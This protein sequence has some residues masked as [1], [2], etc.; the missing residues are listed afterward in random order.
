MSGYKFEAVTGDRRPIVRV[1]RSRATLTHQSM[2]DQI[3][4]RWGQIVFEDIGC[5]PQE[6]SLFEAEFAA[7]VQQAHAVGVH[8]GTLGL[9][10]ALRACGV[11]RHDEV[12]TV[13]NSDISTTAAISHCGAEPVLCDIM[14][15][16]YTIDPARVEDLV[17]PRTAAI[18][19]VDLYGHPAHTKALRPIAER[20]GL[21]D[22]RGCSPGDRRRGLSGFL[23]EP[24]RM[25]RCSA[26]PRLSPWEAWATA[27]W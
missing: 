18:L 8:S 1:P 4:D 13:G 9:F 19:P 2:R 12:I 7:K 24:M 6:R 14:G 3:L 15:D 27:P 22:C 10:L 21:E 5:G 16:D 23:S 11:G 17:T 26:L 25:S 20:F